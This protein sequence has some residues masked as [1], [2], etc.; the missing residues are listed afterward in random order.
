MKRP[1]NFFAQPSN[2][3]VQLLDA[4]LGTNNNDALAKYSQMLQTL[5][6]LMGP[7]ARRARQFTGFARVDWHSAER[8]H[9]TVEGTGADW[10]AP[11]SG[12]TRVSE[13]CGNHSF[14]LRQASQQWV[15]ARWE[16]FITENLL[17]ITRASVGRS[18]QG[19]HPGTPS[20][21][22][23][24][25]NQSAWRRLPQ[26]VIDSRYGFS[27]GNPSRFGPGNFPD[28]RSSRLQ[29]SVNWIRGHALVKAG[30]SYMHSND[31]TSLL[32]NQT[33]TYYYSSVANF[34]SDALVFSTYGLSNALDKFNPHN[35]DQL[36]KPWRDSTGV[37]RGL[38]YLPCYTYY[39]QEM[40]PSQ[41]AISTNDWAGFIAAQWQPNSL[42]VV[43]A[44]MRWDLEQLPPPIAALANPDLPLAG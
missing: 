1:D 4:Q 40:G 19:I 18:I 37:L 8:H 24:T 12:F 26:I 36:G 30:I 33:A 21:Y 44:G 32:R 11:G 7:A 34:I 6:D 16:A 38:G 2:D 41:W 22:E 20:A 17:A 43:S 23:T 42:F 5:N 39:S 27:I 35:C 13:Y 10:D 14:G 3:Q 29:E 9:F 28:E 31:Q 25:L 15:L